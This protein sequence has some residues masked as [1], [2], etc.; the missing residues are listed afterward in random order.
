MIAFVA[1]ATGLTGRAVVRTLR[2]RGIDTIAHIRPD[3]SRLQ[4]WTERWEA[5]GARVDSSAWDADAM[6]AALQREAPDVV[7]SLLGTT[8]KRRSKAGDPVANTYEAVDYGLTALLMTA[9][10]AGGRTPRFVY[11]SSIGAA[12]GRGEYM[13]VRQRIEAQLRD[14]PLP[15]TSV[16]PALILGDRDEPRPGE[17]IGAAVGDGLLK[18]VGAF[19]GKR[20][21]ARYRSIRAPD[22]AAGIVRWALDPSGANRVVE[23]DELR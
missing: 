14:G 8:Q 23:A 17:A 12:S 18:V 13:K 16:R 15:W 3:S 2:E 7:F 22:L 5:L 11:L 9:A 20:V 4:E 21:S 6:E 1:G 10:G 19:G